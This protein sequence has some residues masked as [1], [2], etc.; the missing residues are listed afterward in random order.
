[1]LSES[2]ETIERNDEDDVCNQKEKYRLRIA[3]QLPRMSE[4]VELIH[5]PNPSNSKSKSKGNMQA[6]GKNGLNPN[7]DVDI[8]PKAILPNV[9]VSRCPLEYGVVYTKWGAVSA[10]NVLAGIAAGSE[11]QSVPVDNK[12]KVDNILGATL[13]GTSTMH[14]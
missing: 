3:R 2:I 11:P 7:S 4:E 12:Y 9:A 8:L 1:M 10:G 14:L 5:N 6:P 13:A